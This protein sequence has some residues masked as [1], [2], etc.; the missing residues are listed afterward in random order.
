MSADKQF[1]IIRQKLVSD[2]LIEQFEPTTAK[3]KS[4]LA[5]RL[6]TLFFEQNGSAYSGLYTQL[7]EQR[8]QLIEAKKQLKRLKKLETELSKLTNAESNKWA[9]DKNITIP[10]DVAVVAIKG[11]LISFYSS[12]ISDVDAEVVRLTSAVK[13]CKKAVDDCDDLLSTYKKSAKAEYN[14]WKIAEL[15]T[16]TE[17]IKSLKARL[18]SDED[19]KPLETE[20]AR[21]SN[22]FAVLK[23]LLAV[24]EL[25][26]SQRENFTCRLEKDTLSHSMVR[27]ADADKHLSHYSSKIVK[28]F[29]D[30]V[31]CSYATRLGDLT[32]LARPGYKFAPITLDHVIPQELTDGPVRALYTGILVEQLKNVREP[33][34]EERQ[35]KFYKAVETHLKRTI[36]GN[37]LLKSCEYDGKL[38]ALLTRTVLEF[39]HSIC[40]IIHNKIKQKKIR[41]F[42]EKLITDIFRLT[43]VAW[44]QQPY[45]VSKVKVKRASK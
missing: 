22:V 13:S 30:S 41:T 26:Q 29:T 34:E 38:V 25:S 10:N 7:G 33:S 8:K 1:V 4:V 5:E 35:S 27:F 24:T 9:N 23:S 32:V 14:T 44:G 37:A 16:N 43:Y 40:L 36:K 12:K 17:A 20:I 28:H 45:E 6:N 18:E 31:L 11:Y 15:K 39:N 19:R 42:Q 3:R 2:L 21:L